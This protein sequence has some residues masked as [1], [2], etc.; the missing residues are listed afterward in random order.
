MPVPHAPSIRLWRRRY[1]AH[2]RAGLQFVGQL[3]AQG[4][5]C[6]QIL[7]RLIPAE[8]FRDR[9]GLQSS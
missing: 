2:G 3:F 4:R 9:V 7:E 6:P 1:L 5:T 8:T